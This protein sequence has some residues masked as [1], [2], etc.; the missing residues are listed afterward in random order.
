VIDT[1]FLASIEKNPRKRRLLTT[2]H[3]EGFTTKASLQ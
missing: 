2:K 1:N 3:F